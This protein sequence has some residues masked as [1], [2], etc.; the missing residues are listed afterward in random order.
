MDDESH[1]REQAEDACQK[2]KKKWEKISQGD[3]PAEQT[4]IDE[5]EELRVSLFIY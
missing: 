3:N 5:C 1:L 2:M 4:L